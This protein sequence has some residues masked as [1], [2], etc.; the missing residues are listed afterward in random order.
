MLLWEPKSFFCYGQEIPHLPRKPKICYC[1]RESQ[2]P[3]SALNR[4]K[5]VHKLT[6]C[7]D[8]EYYYYSTNDETCRTGFLIYVFLFTESLYYAA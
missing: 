8:N 5:P 3:H 6:A 4:M 7:I 2:L 1:V